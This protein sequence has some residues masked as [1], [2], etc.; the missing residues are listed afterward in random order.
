[1]VAF[2]CEIKLLLI[3]FHFRKFAAVGVA[4]HQRM[5]QRVHHNGEHRGQ[6]YGAQ[7]N[8]SSQMHVCERFV[9]A[10]AFLCEIYLLLLLLHYRM[11]AWLG[12]STC[13]LGNWRC[14]ALV[15]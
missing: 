5:H 12:T 9:C 11:L 10:V 2:L 1:M 3:L 15:Q 7:R 13:Q 14:D 8:C 6:R 4:W